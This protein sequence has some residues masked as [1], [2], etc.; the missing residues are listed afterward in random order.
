MKNL[1]YYFPYFPFLLLLFFIYSPPFVD[2]DVRGASKP[3][4]QDENATK[5]G[6]ILEAWAQSRVVMQTESLSKPMD[7][8]LWFC[9]SRCGCGRFHIAT[10]LSGHTCGRW[11][12]N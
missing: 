3:R 6:S 9:P 1:S 2:T 7:N 11:E 4:I 8:M 12:S 10:S 5:G